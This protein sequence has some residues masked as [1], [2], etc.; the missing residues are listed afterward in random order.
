MTGSMVPIQF[1]RPATAPSSRSRA[2]HGRT[3]RDLSAWPIFTGWSAVAA[4]LAARGGA[5]GDPGGARQRARRPVRR[6]DPP[7]LRTQLWGRDFP[8]PIGIAAGFDKDARAPRR[9]CGSASA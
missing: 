5:P 7:M 6:A 1:R 8:N 4:R 2:G 9:C 3:G